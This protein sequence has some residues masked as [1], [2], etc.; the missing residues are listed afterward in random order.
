[1]KTER[2]WESLRKGNVER[3]EK[4]KKELKDSVEEVKGNAIALNNKS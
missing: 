1:M 3:R 4:R 2:R